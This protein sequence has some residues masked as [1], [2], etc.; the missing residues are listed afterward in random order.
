MD[1]RASEDGYVIRRRRECLACKR[2][3][4]TYERLEEFGIKVVK[5]EQNSDPFFARSDNQAFADAGV[6]SHTFSVGYIF[7]DY[8]QPGDEWPKLDYE[9]MAK[10]DRTLALGIYRIADSTDVPHW[11]ASNPKTA[12]YRKAAEALKP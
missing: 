8:H 12:A 6:P 7:P 10:V 9:N 11:N 5:D 1:S 2:R 3:Y 4:T